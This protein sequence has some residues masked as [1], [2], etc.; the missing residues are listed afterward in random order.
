M[1]TCTKMYTK[2]NKTKG[3]E[4]TDKTLGQMAKAKL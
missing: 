4:R 2:K 1:I 3:K